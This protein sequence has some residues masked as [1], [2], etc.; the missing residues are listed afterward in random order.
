[1]KVDRGLVQ[2]LS[3]NI[4]NWE[5]KKARAEEGDMSENKFENKLDSHLELLDKFEEKYGMRKIGE[6][7]DRITFTAGASVESENNAIVKISRGDGGK[8]NREEIRVWNEMEESEGRE[9]VA[10]IF[11]WSDRYT[12]I[13]QER[14]SQASSPGASKKLARNLRESGWICSDISPDNIGVKNGKPVLLDL[15][16]GLRKVD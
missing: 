4:S 14:V 8:Q 10:R 7:R 1:M 13:V 12:W 2:E 5:Y 9:Y 6:G 15:G 3:D 16:V 11:D